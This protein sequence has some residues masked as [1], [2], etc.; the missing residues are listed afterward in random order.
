MSVASSD[1]ELKERMQMDA[2]GIHARELLALIASSQLAVRAKLRSAHAPSEF[3]AIEQLSV[4]LD[5]SERVIRK[6]WE[7]IHGKRLN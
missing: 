7:S 2:S 1:Q 5:A 3:K 4:A 6:V